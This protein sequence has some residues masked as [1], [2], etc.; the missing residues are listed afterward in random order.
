MGIWFNEYVQMP[1]DSCENYLTNCADLIRPRINLLPEEIKIHKKVLAQSMIL[2][3]LRLRKHRIDIHS[4]KDGAVDLPGTVIVHRMQMENEVEDHPM[5]LNHGIDSIMIIDKVMVGLNGGIM[6]ISD[7]MGVG[8]SDVTRMKK[9][10]AGIINRVDVEGI[11]G[12]V[13]GVDLIVEVVIRN[14]V[15]GI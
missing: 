15:A 14:E 7:G 4:V 2:L 1:M 13:E 10:H 8:T 12:E 3:T 5:I 11:V 9:C 6:A